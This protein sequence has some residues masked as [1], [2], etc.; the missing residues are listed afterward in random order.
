MRPDDIQCEHLQPDHPGNSLIEDVRRGLLDSPRSI[1]CKYLYDEQG[2]KLFERIC[3]TR[4]YYQ[5]RTE[6]GLLNDACTSIIET[7]QPEQ[8]LELGSGNSSKI[9]V[10]LDS[11]RRLNL[12]CSYMPLDICEQAVLDACNVLQH[13]YS[14]LQVK[15]VVG[16][17]I[18]GL[19]SL[20]SAPGRRL[21]VFLGGTIGNLEEPE[22]QRFF[23]EL[24][25]A[26]N[27]GDWL[28]L[29]A[30]REKDPT[31][32]NAAYND[33]A[34]YTA[35]FNLN[36]LNVLNRELKADFQVEQFRHQA[37]YN[38]RLKHIEIHLVS[39]QAQRV[40]LQEMRTDVHLHE[41]E[42]ILTEISRKFTYQELN[43]LLE[44]QHLQVAHH[45]Q[46]DNEYFSLVLARYSP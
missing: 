25:A 16:D 35:Q 42:K 27:P 37:A 22:R 41:G 6:S 7:S 30:D 8:V 36:I 29:G 11:C 18:H 32:L 13:K 39:Q 43:T 1:P 14:W 40:S 23:A 44:Q 34:G 38:A 46:P 9:H 45:F 19:S 10:L 3:E 15:P 31:I 28:L 5:T 33:S 12:D 2:S 17:Y 4:E 24:L 26:M 21:Y 20:A